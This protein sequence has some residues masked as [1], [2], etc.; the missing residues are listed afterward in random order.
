MEKRIEKKKQGSLRILIVEDEE[1]A[2]KL[3]ARYLSDYGECDTAADGEIGMDMFREASE[4]GKPYDVVFVD[5]LMPRMSGR[6]M[7]EK[8]REFE[9]SSGTVDGDRSGVVMTTSL[10]DPSSISSAFRSR[11]EGYLVKPFG[12]RD[13]EEQLTALGIITAAAGE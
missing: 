5:I 8:I 13:L 7:L 11:C 1:A 2:R 3:T 10:S 4:S 6:K 9:D 12:K